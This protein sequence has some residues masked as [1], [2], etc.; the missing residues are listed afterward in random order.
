M[1]YLRSVPGSFA[2]AALALSLAAPG[3]AQGKDPRRE[4]LRL[5]ALGDSITEAV[6]AEEFN[7]LKLGLTRN[8]WASWAVGYTK[9]WNSLLDR[10]D[11]NSHRQRI[12]AQFGEEGR[13]NKSPAKIGADSEDLLKQAMKAVKNQADYVP[14]LMGQNDICG[15]DA[16][17]IPTDQEFEDN[18]R[19]A[20]E[21]LEAGLPAGATV[22]TLAIVDIYRLW[23]IGDE[24]ELAGIV[25]CS[26]IWEALSSKY[27]PCATML[28]PDL[29]EADRLA[30]RD[31]I[32]GFNTIL[33]AVTEEYDAADTHHYWQY[34]GASFTMD[35]HPEDVSEYDCFHPSEDGQTQLAEETWEDGPFFEP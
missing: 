2:L 10:S 9:D 21:V 12:D 8:R 6:N 17:E 7:P 4:P 5:S 33:E 34:T 29:E 1:R 18:V 3:L 20:F 35:Y 14:I 32:I 31:R 28:D 13:K 30:T 27:I 22:Y 19:A 11:V 23:E 24:L 25:E 15:D 26:E 16:S